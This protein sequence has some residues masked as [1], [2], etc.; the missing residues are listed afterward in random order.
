MFLNNARARSDVYMAI[1]FYLFAD[2]VRA[3]FGG[4]CGYGVLCGMGL[5]FKGPYLFL[6]GWR[7]VRGKGLIGEGGLVR[8]GLYLGA[9]L[10]CRYV[11]L[12]GLRFGNSWLGR[13]VC[14]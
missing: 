11:S 1:L 12:E 2:A 14:V 4:G 5:W 8:G 10:L 6:I 3:M 7:G 13:V 9:L